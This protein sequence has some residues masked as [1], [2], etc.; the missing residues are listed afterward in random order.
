MTAEN[1]AM[2]ENTPAV[3]KGAFYAQGVLLVAAAGQGAFATGAAMYRS[4]Q[5]WN[6]LRVAAAGGA[7]LSGAANDM[8]RQAV[9]MTAALPGTPAQ[10]A[11]LFQSLANQITTSSKGA[12]QAVR[13]AGTN[14]EVVFAGR[15]RVLVVTK[16]G[17]IFT[18]A[19]NGIVAATKET[20]RVMLDVLKEV[21]PK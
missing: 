18:G 1:L 14:G 19:T 3:V 15:D 5:V 20:V 11:Q 8:G 16:D 4:F 10:K 7:A 21:Q 13:M 17:R 12:W 9:R 6:T 2:D